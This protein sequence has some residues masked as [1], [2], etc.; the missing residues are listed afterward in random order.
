MKAEGEETQDFR[1][2]DIF[3]VLINDR[4][5]KLWDY[6]SINDNCSMS[7]VSTTLPTSSPNDSVLRTSASGSYSSGLHTS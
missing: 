4:T 5:Y 3:K 1:C 6:V 2:H 7:D